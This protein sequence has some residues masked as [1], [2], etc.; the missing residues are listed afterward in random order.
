MERTQKTQDSNSSS[1]NVA[2]IKKE[3][4][5]NHE[6]CTLT[7]SSDTFT[8]VYPPLSNQPDANT[9]TLRMQKKTKCLN[10]LP[11]RKISYIT[12]FPQRTKTKKGYRQCPPRSVWR[13]GGD[14]FPR[15]KSLVSRYNDPL[16]GTLK[17]ETNKATR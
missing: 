4:K 3:K 6:A 12:E 1:S 5:R 8:P 2:G 16:N 11:T 15:S 13:T 10:Q 7:S 14:S 9:P 17:Q